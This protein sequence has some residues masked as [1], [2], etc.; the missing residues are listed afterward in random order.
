MKIYQIFYDQNTRDTLD[1]GFIP[2]DN[3]KSLDPSWFEF[4][5][6]KKTLES[7]K[8]YDDEYIAFFSPRF[9]EKTGMIGSEVI[10]IL[11]NTKSDIISFSPKLESSVLFLNCF[12]QAEER[13]PGFLALAKKV[14]KQIGLNID[15]ENLISNQSR[16]IFSNYFVAK[17][18]FW[19]IWFQYA[20]KIYYLSINKTNLISKKVN[21]Q[22]YHRGMKSVPFKVFIMERLINI[23]LEFNKIDVEIC[24]DYK[25]Y[26]LSKNFPQEIINEM[27]LLDSLKTSYIN[28]QDDKFLNLYFEKRIKLFKSIVSLNDK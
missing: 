12:I 18:S 5:S 21:H 22:T 6:I 1:P 14:Y 7:E 13:H 15:I 16:T 28:S 3:S 25:R 24:T 9:T 23:L 11:K 26:Y 17:Y 27:F 4:S 2:L 19:K 10:D 20:L 8:F